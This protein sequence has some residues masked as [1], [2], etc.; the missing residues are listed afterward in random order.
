MPCSGEKNMKK[1]VVLSIIFVTISTPALAEGTSK[2]GVRVEARV[3]WETPTVS[4][5][6]QANDVFKID[7]A[8]AVGA[9]AGYDFKI[10]DTIVVGPYV[11]YESSSAK[12]CSPTDCLKVKGNLAAGIH[13]GLSV[14][15]RGQLYVK[16]GYA[17]M[18]ITAT[19]G[20]LSVSESGSGVQGAIGFEYG[21][22]KN[23]YGRVEFGYG[24]NGKIG[25]VN[26]QRRHAGIGLGARF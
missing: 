1:F 11:N 12:A 18:K 13:A 17:S 3:I 24:D 19:S 8:V 16:A 6:I 21:F 7:S 15:D 20:N 25:G 10:S 9:E 26:F 4:S 14:S 2:S 23:F 5:V 22:G